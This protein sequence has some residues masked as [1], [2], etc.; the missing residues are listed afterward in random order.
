[1]VETN[2]LQLDFS[3][4]VVFANVITFIRKRDFSIP[5]T[6]HVVSRSNVVLKIRHDFLSHNLREV[7]K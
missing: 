6:I 7:N 1:M 2:K 5:S 3:S 4:K